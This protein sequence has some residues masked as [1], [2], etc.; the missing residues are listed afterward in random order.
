METTWNVALLAVRLFYPGGGSAPREHRVP[1]G[2]AASAIEPEIAAICPARYPLHSRPDSIDA[3]SI[4]HIC[5][6][7]VSF[8]FMAIEGGKIR[9]L[10]RSRRCL[11]IP[12]IHAKPRHGRFLIASEKAR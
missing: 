4:C 9:A 3:K 8:P 12:I 1:S 5:A 7:V 6:R 2:I 10:P 11:F